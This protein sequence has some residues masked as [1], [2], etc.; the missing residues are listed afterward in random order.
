M[1]NSL[2]Q[3]LPWRA[4]DIAGPCQQ[5]V[6]APVA[7][8]RE[9]ELTQQAFEM[10]LARL[11]QDRSLAG[12]KYEAVRRKLT[13]FFVWWGSESPE[14]QADETIDRVVRRISEGEEIENLNGYFCGV[15]RLV[16]KES[17]KDQLRKR[18]RLE[19]TARNEVRMDDSIEREARVECYD[20]CLNSLPPGSRELVLRYYQQEGDNK[21]D[22]RRALAVEMGIPMNLLRIRAFRIRKRL[23]HCL[24]ECL[25][26][27][28]LEM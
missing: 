9:W 7:G 4:T 22:Q 10:L 20:K 13:K 15:A 19:H 25:N 14:D 17:L 28:S 12:E 11:D 24:R 8:R 26:R 18:S 21:A 6:D 16:F 5:A 1:E 2:T 3:L 27:R 23:G